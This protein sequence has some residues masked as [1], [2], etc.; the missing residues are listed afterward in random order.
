MPDPSDHLPNPTPPAP[1]VTAGDVTREALTRYLALDRVPNGVAQTLEQIS[2]ALAHGSGSAA[3]EI[4]A[5]LSGDLRSVAMAAEE[6]A[7]LLDPEIDFAAYGGRL[8]A[9]SVLV[10]DVYLA[11]AAAALALAGDARRDAILAALTAAI[12]AGTPPPDPE[13]LR[14]QGSA[15][16]AELLKAGLVVVRQSVADILN[17]WTSAIETSTRGHVLGVPQSVVQQHTAS[18]AGRVSRLLGDEGLDALT[19]KLAKDAIDGRPAPA[20]AS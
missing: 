14:A 13:A 8:A 9:E 12:R 3:A 7:S 4:T 10:P 20:E 18:A 5:K 2:D 16:L 6:L 19:S 11:G 15:A 1:T 17:A